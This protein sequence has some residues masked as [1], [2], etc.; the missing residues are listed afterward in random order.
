MSSLLQ[1]FESQHKGED[2]LKA[3]RKKAWD[4]FVEESLE[5]HVEAQVA[6]FAK[7]GQNA[8]SMLTAKPKEC[9][10][11]PLAEAQRTHAPFFQSKWAAVFEEKDPLSLL[12]L[13]VHSEGVWIYVPSGVVIDEPLVIKPALFSRLHLYLGAGAKLSLQLRGDACQL[14]VDMALE[15]EAQLSVL[16]E[17]GGCDAFRGTL[18]GGARLD[19][20]S[21]VE[22]EA[23]HFQDVAI[24]LAEEGAQ[25][26]FSAL[27]KLHHGA[28]GETR[29][30]MHHSAPHTYSKQALR[31]VLD[32]ASRSM[33][34]GEI[35][36]EKRAQKSEATQLSKALILEKGGIAKSS[37]TLNIHADDVK[38]SH[39]ATVQ[40]LSPSELFYLRSRGVTLSAAKQ[41]LVNA[42][43][44]EGL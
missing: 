27:S 2:S 34:M 9:I 11:L 39:G 30:K 5:S 36:I 40:Q 25:A 22:E 41:L 1:L 14:Y 31:T 32:G 23:F 17:R 4:L 26:S 12:N 7:G 20:V 35:T 18:K 43:C 19:V 8:H 13:A 42:F 16:S 29:I 37:P 3:V 44:K 21:R 10:V 24:T 6:S 28:R 15:K 38:A 33:F